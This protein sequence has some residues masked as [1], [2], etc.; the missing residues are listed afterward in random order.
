MQSTHLRYL[1]DG[2]SPRVAQRVAICSAMRSM[3]AFLRLMNE[4]LYMQAKVSRESS[5]KTCTTMKIVKNRFTWISSVISE[6]SKDTKRLNGD[7]N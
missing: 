5:E 2:Y 7:K 6:K 3:F 1:T 4:G